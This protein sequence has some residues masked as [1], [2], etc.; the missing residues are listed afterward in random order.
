VLVAIADTITV[1]KKERMELERRVASRTG[2]AEDARRARAILLTAEGPMW[3]EVCGEEIHVIVD[4]LSTHKTDQVAQ[5]IEEHPH[6][7]TQL[8]GTGH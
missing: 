3:D 4:N 5:F 2:R 7:S 8:V 1:T 6:I